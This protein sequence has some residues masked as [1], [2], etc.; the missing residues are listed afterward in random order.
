MTFNT[1]LFLVV[2][3]LSEKVTSNSF[4][5]IFCY[6]HIYFTSIVFKKL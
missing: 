6:P 2:S 4:E 5:V 1:K 3:C